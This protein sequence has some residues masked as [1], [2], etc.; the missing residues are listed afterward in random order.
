MVD[1]IALSIWGIDIDQRCC[2][3]T[4]SIGYAAIIAN[5]RRRSVC[6]VI[7]SDGVIRGGMSRLRT[8]FNAN[9]AGHMSRRSNMLRRA[10]QTCSACKL[11]R[12]MVPTAHTCYSNRALTHCPKCQHEMRIVSLINDAQIIERG[13]LVIAPW[14]DDPLPDSDVIHRS[15]GCHKR[16]LRNRETI[17]WDFPAIRTLPQSGFRGE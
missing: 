9:A 13:Q 10:A 8:E 3:T 6:G 17:A 16:D 2:S 15:C 1:A 11:A 7:R 4:D 5:R 12:D 14:L